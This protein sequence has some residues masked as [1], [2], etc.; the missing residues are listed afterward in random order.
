[1]SKKMQ[2]LADGL[3]LP[4]RRVETQVADW[5]KVDSREIQDAI[6]AVAQCGGALRFGYTRDGGAYAVGVYGAGDP[7]TE[8]IRPGED[9]EAY[10]RTIAGAAYA[11][12]AKRPEEP[13]AGKRQ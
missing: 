4:R 9:V 11:S 13:P 12:S 6:A 10:L 1:M 2:Q 5:A 7:Y 3:V 8:Y